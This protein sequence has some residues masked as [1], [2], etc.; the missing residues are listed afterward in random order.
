M[1]AVMDSAGEQ[2]LVP[3]LLRTLER[4]ARVLRATGQLETPTGLHSV[5]RGSLRNF[6]RA[7]SSDGSDMS[8]KKLQ[9]KK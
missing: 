6:L 4:T 5:V 7:E 2:A 3:T 9:V 1:N 8:L